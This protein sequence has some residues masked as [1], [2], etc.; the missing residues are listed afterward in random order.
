MN[1]PEM[2]NYMR[3][4]RHVL[5]AQQLPPPDCRSVSREVLPHWLAHIY[6]A[7]QLVITH[8]HAKM[9]QTADALSQ[10]HVQC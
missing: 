1:L 8:M 7:K 3:Y 6:T 9:H 2:H 5:Y 4:A 10:H